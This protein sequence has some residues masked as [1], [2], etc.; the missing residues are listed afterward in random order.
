MRIIGSSASGLKNRKSAVAL[1]VLVK[2]LFLD[3]VL[4]SICHNLRGEDY[5]IASSASGLKNRKLATV[6]TVFVFVICN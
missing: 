4:G 6:L 3:Q 2:F 5:I 1:T